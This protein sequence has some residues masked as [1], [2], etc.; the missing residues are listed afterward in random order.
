MAVWTSIIIKIRQE[1][2]INPSKYIPKLHLNA[3]VI[4]FRD[5]FAA[6]PV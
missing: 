2:I 4:M 1:F 3:F 5:T 6:Y